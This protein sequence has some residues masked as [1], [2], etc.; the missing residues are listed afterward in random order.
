M[1]RDLSKALIHYYNTSLWWK[2]YYLEVMTTPRILRSAQDDN[3]PFNAPFM[4][5]LLYI[6]NY[7]LLTTN[8]IVQYTAL[9]RYYHRVSCNVKK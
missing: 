6:G 3:A 7:S 1:D 9:T 2:N 5:R 4:E 8:A